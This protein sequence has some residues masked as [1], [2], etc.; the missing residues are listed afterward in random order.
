MVHFLGRLFL[1]TAR[2]DICKVA[3]SLALKPSENIVY[4]F[5]SDTCG[6]HFDKITVHIIAHTSEGVMN[7]LTCAP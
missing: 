3:F 1:L 2:A 7:P 5:V 6:D 4:Y